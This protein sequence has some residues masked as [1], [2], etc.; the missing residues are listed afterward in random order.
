MLDSRDKLVALDEPD[1]DGECPTECHLSCI[2][3]LRLDVI[4]E[5]GDRNEHWTLII[6]PTSL[7]ISPR[8]LKSLIPSLFVDL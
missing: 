3:S 4:T 6:Y 1:D 7:G 5:S 2:N 8:N